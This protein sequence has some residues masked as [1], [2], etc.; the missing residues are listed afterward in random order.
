MM[1]HILCCHVAIKLHR[2]LQGLKSV[3]SIQ[4]GQLWF[5]EKQALTCKVRG[6][7]TLSVARSTRYTACTMGEVCPPEY[8]SSQCK[9][10]ACAP[11]VSRGEFFVRHAQQA[12][13]LCTVNTTNGTHK[14]RVV[15]L[16]GG[17][18]AFLRIYN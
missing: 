18:S 11:V 5:S 14:K 3:M 4:D 7:W 15:H 9:L 12:F 13:V 8:S 1:R 2:A 16:F 6:E 10:R 17:P